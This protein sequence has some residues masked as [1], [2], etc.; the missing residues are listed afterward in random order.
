MFCNQC[1]K[2]LRKT[3]VY[4]PECGSKNEIEGNNEAQYTNNQMPNNV[5]V[6]LDKHGEKRYIKGMENDTAI[7]ILSL[8]LM[9]GVPFI[10][11]ILSILSVIP[12]IGILTTIVNM[13]LAFAPLAALALAI[14]ARVHYK[15]SRFAKILLIVYIV[16][17]VLAIIGTIIIIIGC[18]NVLESCGEIDMIAPLFLK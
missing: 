14:Y 16:E 2:K 15:E 8:I 12:I 6:E 18:V 5:Q 13:L 11:V 1:G 3:D 9:Y 17:A 7:C 10:S 4:C